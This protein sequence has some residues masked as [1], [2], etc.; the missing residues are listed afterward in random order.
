MTWYLKNR[1]LQNQLDKISNGS[2]SAKLQEYARYSKTNGERIFIVNFSRVVDG[3]FFDNHC[4]IIFGVEDVEELIEDEFDSDAW[5]SFPTVRPPED[6]WM[7]FEDL[8]GDGYRVRF[9]KGEWLD[10]HNDIMKFDAGRYRPWE[11]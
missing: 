2:F 5:N 3:I 8:V 10:V 4:H 11:D 6:V 7:R 9:E 1:F